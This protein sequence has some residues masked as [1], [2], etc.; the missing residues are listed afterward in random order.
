ML[1]RVMALIL[2]TRAAEEESNEEVSAVLPA[3]SELCYFQHP[4]ARC[5]FQ[6]DHCAIWRS[7]LE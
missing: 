7:L 1:S 6:N 5:A 2:G 4:K 3:P